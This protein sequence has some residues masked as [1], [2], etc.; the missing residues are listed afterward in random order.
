MDHPFIKMMVGSY[1]N[2]SDIVK[3]IYKNPKEFQ[4]MMFTEMTSLLDSVKLEDSSFYF[5]LHTNLDR[6]QQ[7]KV[8][9]HLIEHSLNNIHPNE[10]PMYE[11]VALDD[12]IM[13][14]EGFFSKLTATHAILSGLTAVFLM[15]GQM[16]NVSKAVWG[17]MSKFANL[18]NKIH[19]YIGKFTKPG[20]VKLAVI[21]NS[22][23][24]CYA[25]CGITNIKD[26]SPWTGNSISNRVDD[27]KAPIY[28][29]V[30]TRQSREQAECLT[31]CYLN[32]SLQQL[33][34]LLTSYLTCLRQ[35]GERG[36]DL[37][38]LKFDFVLPSNSI[39]SPYQKLIKEHRAAYSDILDVVSVNAIE[40]E[41][42][43]RMYSD[44][45]NKAFSATSR[46]NK[47][48]SQPTQ[49]PKFNTKPNFNK[50]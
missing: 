32:W 50:R 15:S 12:Y 35:T 8:L 48:F 19:D 6:G 2:D 30:E 43:E 33:E 46:I 18:N 20:R 27:S 36:T 7:Q 29:T 28:R 31:D 34:I 25:K 37:N 41:K 9:Y 24:E 49:N 3:T 45:L 21:Y 42:Y 4:T 23:E 38:D 1:Y 5:E 44:V 26:I 40:R 16:R 39:C 17:M 13:F 10:F 14:T 11:E 47:P 22:V